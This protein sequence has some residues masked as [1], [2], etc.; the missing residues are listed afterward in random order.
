MGSRA[1]IKVHGL[2]SVCLSTGLLTHILADN[3][4]TEAVIRALW[5]LQMRH[6]TQI[7]HIHSDRGTQFLNIGAVGSIPDGS[8]G[9][10]I[11]LLIMVNAVRISEAQ[12]QSSNVVEPLVLHR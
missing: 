12:G 7:T 2:I 3:I 4:T 9:P 10:F 8:P 5:V 1:M 11:R 6:G